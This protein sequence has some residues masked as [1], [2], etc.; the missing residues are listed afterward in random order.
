[1]KEEGRQGAGRKR[2]ISSKKVLGNP[3]LYAQFL[4]SN[5]KIPFLKNVRPE[6]IEDVSERYIPYLGTEF[7]SD[8]VKRVHIHSQKGRENSVSCSAMDNSQEENSGQESFFLV[9]LTEHKSQVDYDVSMQLLKY[10][11]CI[12]LDYEKEMEQKK[13]GASDR[14][15]FRYPLIIPVVYYEG[16]APWTADC[17]FRT[18]VFWG[19]QFREWIPDF[20]YE[21]VRLH[22]YSN[23]ELLARGDEM[24]LIMLFNKIQ[25]TVDLSE[26]LKLPREKLNDIVKD[27]PEAILD[28]IASVMESLCVKIGATE[29]EMQECVSRVKER[30]MGY[31]FENIEKMDIQAERRNTAQARAEA[32]RVR[33]EAQRAQEE[34]QRTQEEAQEN[35]IRS[36]IAV[37]QRLN[38]GKE[39]AVQEVIEVCGA[40]RDT[41]LEK[42]NLYWK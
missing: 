7:E 22:D 33:E 12:W 1:M 36:V 2:D 11:L 19:E 28:I 20:T 16:K 31:L 29:E 5:L 13:A 15:S 27:T 23:E 10:M 8:T 3:I 18:R 9:F 6:D 39:Q 30:R 37:C 21:V 42:V 14:K 26:F 41:A 35:A 34:A 32:Q 17:R 40:D 4:R 25:D 24:S 38:A